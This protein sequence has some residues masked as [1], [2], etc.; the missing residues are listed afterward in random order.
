MPARRVHSNTFLFLLSSRQ[1]LFQRAFEKYIQS[2]DAK[3]K[4]K[5]FFVQYCDP[6]KPLDPD[7][8]NKM[9]Q[10]SVGERWLKPST[11]RKVLRT[12]AAIQKEYDSVVNAISQSNDTTSAFRKF[13]YSH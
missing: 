8:I 10:A 4:A 12:L 6:A 1:P 11:T 7:E 13:T 5:D 9:L 2:L 3:A